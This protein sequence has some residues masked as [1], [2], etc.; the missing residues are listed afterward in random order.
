MKQ[1]LGICS[2]IILVV[3]TTTF[4]SC[5][6]HED[7]LNVL[8]T[9]GCTT[10]EGRFTTE[11]GNTPIKDVGLELDWHTQLHIGFPF[12]GRTRRIATTRTDENG[13]YKI[14]FLAKDEELIGGYYSI[15]FK[16]PDNSFI[17]QANY[18]NFHIYGI[19]KR[20]TLVARNYHLPKKGATLKVRIK[21]PLSIGGNDRLIC[22]VSYK[23][24][25]LSENI[26]FGV[27]ELFSNFGSEASFETAA[28]QFSYIRISKEINGKDTSALDSIF[29][30][31]NE[32]RTFDVEF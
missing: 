19:Q 4:Q 31:V 10:I 23:Y 15:E 29:I 6:T 27:G 3:L 2:T 5:W 30:P 24:D 17:T 1:V 8:C 25:D 11:T 12:P 21:N 18:S 32:T 7:A 26:R 9:A 13:N 22:E 14:V 16:P 20:D 28:N